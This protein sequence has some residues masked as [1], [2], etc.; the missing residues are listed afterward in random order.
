[1]NKKTAKVSSGVVPSAH[2]PVGSYLGSE[3]SGEGLVGSDW[4]QS[5]KSN[6]PLSS[7][8]TIHGTA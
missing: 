4:V 3:L 8:H 5:G 1:M 6:I 2:H 7:R